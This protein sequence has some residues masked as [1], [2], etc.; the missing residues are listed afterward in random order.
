MGDLVPGFPAIPLLPVRQACRRWLG[1]LSTADLFKAER[2]GRVRLTRID[3][4]VFLAADDATA[5]IEFSRCG[6]PAVRA[7]A[8]A[9][10]GDQ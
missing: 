8:A 1:G 3:G 2:D 4:K 10:E 9:P 7:I 5:L 6:S